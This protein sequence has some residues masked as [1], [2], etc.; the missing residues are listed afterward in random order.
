MKLRLMQFLTCP[1]CNHQP[2]QLESFSEEEVVLTEAH[3]EKCQR[4]DIDPASLRRSVVEGLLS[5]DNCQTWFPIKSRIPVLH[6]FTHPFHAQFE[7]DFRG[8]SAT[9]AKYHSPRSE[10]RPHELHTLRNYTATWET[11]GEGELHFYLTHEQ[12][13]KW[14]AGQ[15]EWPEWATT[16]KN[17]RILDIGVGFGYEPRTLQSVID[18]EIFAVDLN[19]S[20]L[21]GSHIFAQEPFIHY[22]CASLFDIPLPKQDFDVVV[23][24]GVLHHT[25]STRDAFH[26]IVKHMRDTGMVFIWIYWSEDFGGP[27]KQVLIRLRE[28]AI[29]PVV[30][31]MPLWLQNCI[32]YVW[33]WLYFPMEKKKVPNPD[34]WKFKNT[35]G[36]LRDR[37]TPVYAYRHQFFEVYDWMEQAEL[38]CRPV[39]M[40]YY[41]KIT[42]TWSFGLSFRAIKKRLSGS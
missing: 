13:K 16:K 33:A 29:R 12:E 22:I 41:K 35:L 1:C 27:F 7:R 10:G 40:Y 3:L 14:F 31:R 6:K 30:S 20:L 19:L 42:G 36:H 5:C 17:L 2:L 4:M 26:A 25:Y 11:I 21:A 24:V 39:D 9:F 38:E 32:L 15:L 18:G 34:K 23:C 28:L 8:R 37:Y